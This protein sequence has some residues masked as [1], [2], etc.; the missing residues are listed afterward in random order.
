M[1]VSLSGWYVGYGIAF[2][3]LVIVVALVGMI[4]GLAR[5]IGVQ[6]L[7][8]NEA[9]DESR[10]NTLALWDLDK[11]NGGVRSIISSAEEARMALEGER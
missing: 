9:L 1:G 4:L 6:A 10:I 11:L 7:A 8:V 2:V 5:R 3:V